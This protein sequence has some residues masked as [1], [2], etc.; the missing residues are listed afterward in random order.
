VQAGL[1]FRAGFDFREQG[2][3][4]AA[5]ELVDAVVASIKQVTRNFHGETR[6]AHERTAHG[7]PSTF[8]CAL[9]FCFVHD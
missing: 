6:D 1:F 3:G 7:L 4:R 9:S 2:L 5:S 8:G